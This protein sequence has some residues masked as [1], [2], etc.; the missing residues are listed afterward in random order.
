[1]AKNQLKI[2]WHNE[3]RKVADLVPADY[4]P[5]DLTPKERKDLQVSI[6]SFGEVEPV[7][8]N[9]GSRANVLIGGH[10]RVKV[11]ADLGVEEISVRVPER[12]LSIAEET[13]LNIRLNKNTGHF[14]EKLQQFDRD[15]LLAW[16]F[17]EHELLFEPKQTTTDFKL[18]AGN[19]SALEQITFTLAREQA[20]FIA[21]HIKGVDT[22]EE[23]F[24]NENRNGNAIYT[25]VKQWA[26][27]KK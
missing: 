21:N 2:K 19:K 26:E 1:M 13:E 24:G 4:N 14:N 10:Q 15:N 8:L 23:T 9:I 20:Q 6:E 27:P 5:R 18:P 25:I 17:E 7:V 3:V 16:G 12:E 22:F 11:Y